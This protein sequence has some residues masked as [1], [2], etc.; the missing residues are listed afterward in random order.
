MTFQLG[1]ATPKPPLAHNQVNNSTARL[2]PFTADPVFIMLRHVGYVYG[3]PGKGTTTR[4]AIGRKWRSF[5]AKF[6][7]FIY[8]IRP[9]DTVVDWLGFYC[10]S[11][12]YLLSFR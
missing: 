10:Y 7:T 2:N 5:F 11:I 4:T 12:F 9:P 1:N 3:A 8:N 6:I